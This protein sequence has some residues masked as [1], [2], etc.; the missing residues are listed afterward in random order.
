VL[1]RIW[2]LPLVH[3]AQAQEKTLLYFRATLGWL[4]CYLT[5]YP[6]GAWLAGGWGVLAAYFIG[7]F[8]L[9][10]LLLWQLHAEI[11]L[12]EIATRNLAIILLFL[13]FLL[14]FLEPDPLFRILYFFSLALL[15]ILALRTLGII[16]TRDL[17]RIKSLLNFKR[18][19]ALS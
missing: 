1:L 12:P 5:F 14:S 2:N 13:L 3:L 16:T 9:A 8:I 15:F 6:L 18:L 4:F 7:E 10:I 17:S 11:N 19:F